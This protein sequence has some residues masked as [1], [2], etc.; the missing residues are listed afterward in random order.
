MAGYKVPQDVEADDKLI[1]PF[2]FRQFIYLI[3]VAVGILLAWFLGQIFIGLI[4]IPMPFIIF[5]GALALPLRKDQPMEIYLVAVVR[6]FFK[7]RLRLWKPEGQVNLVTIVAPHTEE[8]NLTKDFTSDEA[9]ARLSYLSKVIDTQGWAARGVNVSDTAM[10]SLNDDITAEANTIDDMLDDTIGIG[11]Q[12]NSL[13]EEQDE[14]RR[15]TITQNFQSAM[16]QP[17]TINP[18][19]VAQEPAV[20]TDNPLT[21][22]SLTSPNLETMSMTATDEPQVAPVFQNEPLSLP[23]SMTI[24]PKP[25]SAYVRQPEPVTEPIIEQPPIEAPNASSIPPSP[26]I[27]NLANNHNLSISGIAHEA[28]RLQDESDEVVVRLR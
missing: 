26:D 7:P 19:V 1:G 14:I 13:I 22:P 5:F 9:Q 16:S 11:R 2:S 8:V 23:Q 28:H 15:Q 12:F 21:P 10:A 25:A 20:S 4:L 24:T 17:P 6:F 27:M 3:V 18:P